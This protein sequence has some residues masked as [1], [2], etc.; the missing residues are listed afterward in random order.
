M[1]YCLVHRTPNGIKGHLFYCN[2]VVPDAGEVETP[3]IEDSRRSR[4]NWF[5]LLTD[6][7]HANTLKTPDLPTHS[8]V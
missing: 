7:S 1:L 6:T 4:C 5:R 8:M 3:T 2:N